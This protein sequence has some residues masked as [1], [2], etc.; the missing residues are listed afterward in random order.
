MDASEAQKA[1]VKLELR[2][3]DLAVELNT[4]PDAVIAWEEGRIRV[5]KHAAE[6][7]RWRMAG[8]ERTEA[9]ESSGLPECAWIRSLKDRPA[10][11]DMKA[12]ARRVEEINAHVASCDV[13]AAREAYVNERF[14]PMPR[15]PVR[16]WLAVVVPIF[17]RIARLPEWARPAATGAV[18]FAAYSL[19]R[20]VFLLPSIARD[21]LHGLLTALEGVTLSA[22]I[23]AALGLVY[24][25]YR[26]FR[27]RRSVAANPSR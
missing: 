18:L 7:L 26:R 4:T 1:R 10:P 25:Q 6:L 2:P 3:V 11:E 16:G 5:P 23:G 21:P 20:V 13:C 24:G 9:L 17:D 27:D 14:P 12:H 8:L 19:I 15:V 22:S